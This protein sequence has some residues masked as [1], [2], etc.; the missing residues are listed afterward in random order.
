MH[1]RNVC[2]DETKKRKVLSKCVCWRLLV[3]CVRAVCLNVLHSRAQSNRILSVEKGMRATLTQSTFAFRLSVVSISFDIHYAP[4]LKKQSD[5]R[6]LYA[7]IKRIKKNYI[8]L[9]DKK[10]DEHLQREN[11]KF[12]H[13]RIER[14]QIV[15]RILLFYDF[16]KNYDIFMKINFT[17]FNSSRWFDEFMRFFLSLFFCVRTRWH[18]RENKVAN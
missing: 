8:F 16:F 10:E 5:A 17:T 1:D 13:R 15:F 2:V 7:R 12:I 11:A 9:F 18:E 14:G 4:A 3:D 6:S